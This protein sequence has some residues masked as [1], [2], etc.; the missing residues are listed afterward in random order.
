MK[1][2]GKIQDKKKDDSVSKKIWG[3]YLVMLVFSL[4]IIGKIIYIQYFWEPD[5]KTI[6]HFV[7]RAFKQTVKPERG[8][9]L[10]CNGKELAISTPVY[11]IKMDCMVRKDY[12]AGMKE[13]E[14]GRQAEKEWRAEA[15]ELS[16][17]LA[18]TLQE[19]GKSADWYY[20]AII[21]RRDN[22]RTDSRAFVIVKAADKELLDKLKALPLFCEGQYKGGMIAERV[23]Q[24][25]YPYGS[26]AA[27]VIGYSKEYAGEPEK[28]TYIGIEGQYGNVLK[29]IPGYRWMK[30][31]DK[32]MIPDP[33]SSSVETVNGQDI[34]TTIDINIQD[35]ADR[36]LRK[37]I[38]DKEVIEGGCV[39][40]ME[41]ETGAIRAMVNLSKNKD[42]RLGE[43]YNMAIGRAGEPGS[44]FK[45]VT[46]T[47]LLEDEKINLGT[48][49]PTNGGKMENCPVDD[50]IPKWSR[51]HNNATQISVLDGFKISSNYVFRYLVKENYSRE[52]KEYISRL[53]QYHLNE[54]CDCGLVERG[55]ATPHIPDPKGKYW[56]PT[57]L[58]QCAI[59]YGVT[60]TPLNIA[61]FYNA[62]AND[63]TMMN[64]YIIDSFEKD[65]KTTMKT[66]PHALNKAICSKATADTLTR[67][68]RSVTLEGTGS[69]VKNAKVTIAGKTGTSR[70]ALPVEERANRHDAYR[71]K[72]GKVKYQATYVGFFPSDEPKY[73]AIVTIYTHPSS[74]G[75]YGGSIPAE[76]V[77]EIVNRLWALDPRWGETIGKEGKVPAMEAKYIGT[78]AGL[79]PNVI[80]MGLKDAIYAIEN[81]GYKLAYEGSGHVTSQSLKAGESGRKGETIKITLQ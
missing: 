68:L 29:G 19:K 60:S 59:G 34:R 9:I 77:N 12:Y 33:D 67:A 3:L 24:R 48:K 73:T 57:D 15:K 58:L 62:I 70:I 47:T 6:Q 14:D 41:V 28:N 78:D 13:K 66:K 65:G 52:P 40:V 32:G 63:G 50:Y 30:K 75:I 7:P 71:D 5:G 80:G 23:T 37:R 31:T 11:D 18:R 8:A 74:V 2:T 16:K 45:A 55:G 17:G 39:V 64:P 61:M 27:R 46:M 43:N 38:E 20:K 36:A 10:D 54:N 35:I 44:V 26:L 56:S 22:K 79:V 49:I 25:Q 72:D 53:Y 76:T 21:D 81:S 4:V 1:T 42:G 69:K 51:D